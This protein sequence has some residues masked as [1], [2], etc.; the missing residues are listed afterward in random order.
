MVSLVDVMFSPNVTLRFIVLLLLA[1]SL[2]LPA[3]SG[4]ESSES[5]S[6]I[7]VKNAKL[8]LIENVVVA[9]QDSGIIESVE[10]KEGDRV[11][12]GQRLV[13]LESRVATAEFRV[14]KGQEVIARL[15]ADND[16]EIRFAN[17]SSQVSK[18]V[19][20]RSDSAQKQFPK[21]ISKTELERLKLDYQRAQLS[22]EQ[23]KHTQE[24]SEMTQLLREQQSEVAQLRL[25]NRRVKSPLKGTVVDVSAKKGEWVTAG[26]PL[27]RI[28]DPSRLQVRAL[29]NQVHAFDLAEGSRAEFAV[30]WNE[31]VKTAAGV[32]TFV[33]PEINPISE[34]FLVLVE[35][36]NKDNQFRSGL[37]GLLK[38]LPSP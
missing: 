8:T 4:Q 16:I 6:V 2:D 1:A 18:K 25:E 36:D 7:T 27:A 33:S 14:A 22:G 38:L 20:E 5:P 35:I 11:V 3:S 9:A 24:I 13:Q 19:F 23:A 17:M 34:E 12:P 30:Q 37:K 21:S 26:E 10:I 31:E 32:V 15:E 28:I 29:V